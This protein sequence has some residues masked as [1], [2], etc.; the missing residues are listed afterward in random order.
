MKKTR[1]NHQY[2]AKE[3]FAFARLEVESGK[4]HEQI[5]KLGGAVVLTVCCVVLVEK[6]WSCQILSGGL[7]FNKYLSSTDLSEGIKQG[8]VQPFKEAQ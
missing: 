2:L 1:S 3:L 6:C 4:S 5:T 7:K 8:K